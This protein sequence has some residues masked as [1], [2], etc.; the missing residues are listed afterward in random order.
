MLAFNS[1]PLSI[2]KQHCMGGGD[3]NVGKHFLMATNVP[4]VFIHETLQRSHR[5]F[6][7]DKAAAEAATS[8]AC[9]GGFIS[10]GSPDWLYVAWN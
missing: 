7:A 4:P 1:L 5:Q 10:H 9:L 8:V 2:F 3:V 6:L